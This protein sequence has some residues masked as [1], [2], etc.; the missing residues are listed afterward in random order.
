[1]VT[2]SLPP[3]RL[4]PMAVRPSL[5][6][7]SDHLGRRQPQI[8]IDAVEAV[9]RDAA[10]AP[11]ALVG[12]EQ[13]DGGDIGREVERVG[14]E[15]ALQR[16]ASVG[17][18]SEHAFGAV[19]VEFDIDAGET[20]AAADH[21][22]LRL[23]GEM[24]EA[25]AGQRLLPEPDQRVAQRG[26]IGGERAFDLERRLDAER[27]FEGALSAARWRGEASSPVRLPASAAAKS[28]SV[29]LASTGS[30]CQ[31]KRPVA[32]K[33]LEIDGQASENC[34]SSSVSVV[35]C[36]CVAQ[37]HGAVVDAHL[38]E[39]GK[40]LRVRLLAA[41]Q[42]LRSA[43][44]SWCGRSPRNRWRWS[45]FPATRRRSRRGRP[46]AERSA[47]ARSAARR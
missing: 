35:L 11:A 33:L 30:S 4:A 1:M 27:A 2:V 37:H 32:P 29:R 13:L 12:G 40:P 24:A 9:E 10:V 21:V 36:A 25:A 7:A 26:R 14:G 28:P 46:A 19:A 15:R 41:R 3:R 38:G 16:L 5:A 17:R 20:D 6:S 47:G 39:G 42:R 43:P 18:V 34:T 31:M 8:E 23:D 44:T 22:G 45:G